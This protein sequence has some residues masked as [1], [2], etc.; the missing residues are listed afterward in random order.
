MTTFPDH[1]GSLDVPSPSIHGADYGLIGAGYPGADYRDPRTSSTQSLTPSDYN[2]HEKRKLL[3]VYIHG[4]MGNDNSFQNFPFHVHRFLRD[5]LRESHAVHTKIYPRYKTYKAIEVARDNFSRWLQP[6]ESP[7]TDVVLVGHSMGGL[8]AAEV[9]LMPNQ[10]RND[11]KMSQ[12]RILGTVNLDA[13]LLG[14]HPGIITSGIASLFRKKPDPPKPPQAGDQGSSGESS[15]VSPTEEPSIIPPMSRLTMD[16]NFNPNFTNDVRLKDR[17]WWKNVVHFVSKHNQEGLMDAA[18][19]HI[20]SH[21]EFGSCLMDYNGMKVRYESLRRLEDVN[22]IENRGMPHVPSRVRFVQYYT[23]C[24]GYPKKPKATDT[25]DSKPKQPEVSEKSVAIGN[26]GTND[27][28]HERRNESA[29]PETESEVESDDEPL[30]I[31]PPVPEPESEHDSESNDPH[32]DTGSP[33][34]ASEYFAT[35]NASPI[36]PIDRSVLTTLGTVPQEH[37]PLAT[38]TQEHQP[39]TTQKLN[40]PK[41]TETGRFREDLPPNAPCTVEAVLQA[42]IDGLPPLPEPPQKPEEP[43]SYDASNKEIRKYVEKET[44]RRNKDY[45]KQMKS[46]RAAEA[47]RNKTIEKMRAKLAAGKKEAKDKQ[48][49]LA[50]A[51]AGVVPDKKD[52]KSE[53][54]PQPEGQQAEGSGQDG[55]SSMG[56]DSTADP[57]ISVPTL[58]RDGSTGALTL[59]PDIYGQQSTD[60]SENG[61]NEMAQA[62]QGSGSPHVQFQE[63]GSASHSNAENSG[64]LTRNTS[65]EEK[66]KAPSKPEKP[67]K[68]PKDRKFCTCPSKI[69]GQMDPK[70]V[71]IFMKDVDEVAAH[72]GLFFAGPHYEKLVG[73]VGELICEWVQEDATTRF[74]MDNV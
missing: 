43:K 1:H 20:T 28:H 55:G 57:P 67:S 42:F 63:A 12:H 48:G 70:W 66:R 61:G 36:E 4:F 52:H 72:T 30:D 38:E 24:H 17:G 3:L 46:W 60:S 13:P 37:Q 40:A 58:E 32:S 23:V 6:H 5:R 11:I 27:D 18:T 8:L 29:S 31:L 15:A 9:A 54:R 14:L 51:A 50:D 74:I 56:H 2:E 19:K 21:L 68:P 34:D 7:D 41:R 71:K 73:D 59:A 49:A 25:E 26:D 47:S 35:A 16:P 33:G 44:K 65:H 45:E 22:D 69:N 10:D 62:T 53:P 39:P 64:A